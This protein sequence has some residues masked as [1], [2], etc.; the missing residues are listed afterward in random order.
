MD[1]QSRR[2]LVRDYKERRAPAGVFVVRC[3]ATGEVWAGSTRD[4]D[5]ERNKLIFGLRMGAH[6]NRPMQAAWNAHGEAGLSYEVV[7]R[8]DD[9]DLTPRGLA[10]ELKARERHWL[11]ALAAKRAAG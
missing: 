4:V 8:I 7:E 5:A 2:Q 11:E 9:P 10:D 1:K 3:P 6:Q